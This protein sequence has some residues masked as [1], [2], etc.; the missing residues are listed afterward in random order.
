VSPTHTLGVEFVSDEF[1][2]LSKPAEPRRKVLNL[3]SEYKLDNF[4]TIKVRLSNSGEVATA[5]EHRFVSPRG[6]VNFSSQWKAKGTSSFKA[7]KFGIGFT[8]GGF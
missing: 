2:R 7:E 4:T 8:L 6:A 1:D 5:V 3:G